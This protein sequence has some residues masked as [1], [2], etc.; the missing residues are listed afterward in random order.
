MGLRGRRSVV[1]GTASIR[2]RSL[3]SLQPS[4]DLGGPGP[5][6][7]PPNPRGASGPS[8]RLQPLLPLLGLL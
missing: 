2:P 1:L 4:G 7:R 5:A 8:R 6:T 3:V